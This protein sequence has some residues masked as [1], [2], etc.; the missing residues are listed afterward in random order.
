MGI[1]ADEIDQKE[2][3][4]LNILKSQRTATSGQIDNSSI[5]NQSQLPAVRDFSSVEILSILD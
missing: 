5:E 1:T 3:E 2:E 4:I